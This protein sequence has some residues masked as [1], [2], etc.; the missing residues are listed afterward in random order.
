MLSLQD[1]IYAHIKWVD[2]EL[3][4]TALT[5]KSLC[6][7]FNPLMA[8]MTDDGAVS[9]L[10]GSKKRFRASPLSSTIEWLDNAGLLPFS[11]LTIM[12]EKL[13][14]LRDSNEIDDKDN[15]NLKKFDNDLF[16]WSLGEGVSSWST[17][18]ALI[19]LIDRHNL[20]LKH[21]SKI[22]EAVIWLA[23]QQDIAKSGWAYQ[24]H[25]NC[26]VNAIMTS[27]A[28]RAITIAFKHKDEFKFTLD[29]ER[30]LL[31]VI[32][33]GFTYLR[34]SLINKGNYSYWV[35]N[36]VPH[37]AATTWALLALYEMKKVTAIKSRI[38]AFYSDNIDRC[39]SFVLSRMPKKIIYWE[40]EQIVFES[41]AKYNKQKNYHSFSASLLSQLFGL[42]LSPY[43]PKVINQIIWLINNSNQWKI[44]KY[45]QENICVFT[46]AMVLATIT[47]WVKYV[48]RINALLL[49]D[50]TPSKII[51]KITK[52]ILGTKYY[53]ELP[54]QLVRTNRFFYGLIFVV[55]TFFTL[56]FGEKVLLFFKGVIT[57]LITLWNSSS[58]EILVNIVASVL[59]GTICLIGVFILKIIKDIYRRWQH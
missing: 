12:Q 26:E 9:Y 39:I 52:F 15:G 6:E 5:G 44:K 28:L 32:N 17:S 4:F 58:S 24:L 19:A 30:S 25:P 50:R 37:C 53:K 16:G 1:S 22:K 3:N 29:E 54:V 51:D 35:F 31:T 46:Y 36:N 42:G 13:L 38:E 21:T 20:W 10:I 45:D 27:L 57:N 43:H 47:Q 55:F 41:G 18:V 33:N 59:Y 49:L 56:I 40:D 2:E 14:Y 8:S 7:W 11:A 23:G 48:G 34:D